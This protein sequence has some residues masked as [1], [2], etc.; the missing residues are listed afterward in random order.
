MH[1][2]PGARNW[3]KAVGI[4]ICRKIFGYSLKEIAHVFEF[5]RYETVS[6]I[7]HRSHIRLLENQGLYNQMNEVIEKIKSLF[8]ATN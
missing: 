6:S 3:P 2:N 1:G 7:V 4:Y 8:Y 5:Y